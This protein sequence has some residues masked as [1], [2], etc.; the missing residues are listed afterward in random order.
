MLRWSPLILRISQFSPAS[1]AIMVTRRF[2]ENNL[3]TSLFLWFV[4][5]RMVL[6]L[7]TRQ[8]F[9]SY[10]L[11]YGYCNFKVHILFYCRIQL[12][13]ILITVLSYWTSI[14]NQVLS[15]GAIVIR[16]MHNCWWTAAKGG[17]AYWVGVAASALFSRNESSVSLPP[18]SGE[19]STHLSFA[20]RFAVY[21]CKFWLKSDLCWRDG[22]SGL[23]I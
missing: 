9:S 13:Y 12:A 7:R 6:A 11:E 4:S 21:D 1:D 10:L 3:F 8:H 15:D 18:P 17:G 14:K 19:N 20:N 2:W 5:H 23:D 16:L 22:V